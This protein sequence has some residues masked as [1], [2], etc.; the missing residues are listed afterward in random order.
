MEMELITTHI[1]K[2]SELG[3]HGN[4]FGGTYI[5]ELMVEVRFYR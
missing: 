5:V 1:C 4:M 2:G 3:V